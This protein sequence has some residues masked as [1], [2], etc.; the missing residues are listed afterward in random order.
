MRIT[1]WNVHF[2]K[3]VEAISKAFLKNPNLSGSDIVLLQEIESYPSEGKARA[4]KIAERLGYRCV[5]A[6]ARTK[7]KD[8]SHGIAIL[9]RF[10]IEHA[11]T[12]QLPFIR[13][14]WGSRNRIALIAKINLPE[15]MVIVCNVHLD[16]RI[17]HRARIEQLRCAVERLHSFTPYP[18]I[19]GGDFNTSPFYFAFPGLPVLPYSQRKR[20]ERYMSSKGFAGMPRA[21]LTYRPAVIPMKLDHIY[22]S[23]IRVADCGVEK[24]VRVSDHRPV[25][26]D[27]AFA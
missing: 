13:M 2:G 19:V 4:E 27:L 11:E 6:A 9:S 26:A 14:P 23:G 15:G 21:P 18:L 5:Y 3:N 25:W 17:N 16:V 7:R 24:K 10:P 1:T 12:V 20:V 22:T 8:G